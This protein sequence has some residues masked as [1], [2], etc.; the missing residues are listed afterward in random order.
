MAVPRLAQ[1]PGQARVLTLRKLRQRRAD[2]LAFIFSSSFVNISHPPYHLLFT[3]PASST[4]LDTLQSSLPTP[5]ILPPTPSSFSPP[6]PNTST[7]FARQTFL[8][9]LSPD[10][11]CYTGSFSP[12]FGRL[13]V[14]HKWLPFQ[15]TGAMSPSIFNFVLHVLIGR[16]QKGQ[17]TI[18][19]SFGMDCIR[20]KEF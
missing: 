20:A 1:W 14:M 12:A 17:E 5:P 13:P 2:D 3:I 9:Y 16:I 11:S 19:T 8:S 18:G 15:S 4:H 7:C 10:F 6:P